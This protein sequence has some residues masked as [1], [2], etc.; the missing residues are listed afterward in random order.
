MRH[1]KQLP[2]TPP[3][4]AHEHAAELTAISTLLD[5][6]PRI[7]AL[8]EQDLLRTCT[9][10]PATGRPGLTGDQV[11][12][13]ALVRQMN[14]WSYDEL[15]FHLADSASYRAFCRVSPLL[16]PPSRAALAANLRRLRPVT[17]EAINALVIT[18][19]AARRIESGQMVRIDAT[20]VVAA[21]H[22]P[23]DASLLWDGIRV[24]LRLL[25]RAEHLAGFTAY[26]THLKRAKRQLLAIQHAAPQATGQRRAAYR[27]LLALARATGDYATCALVHLAASG[28]PRTTATQRLHTQLAHYSGLLE[29]VID[30]TTRRV[31]H[32]ESVPATEKL[33][34]LFETHVDVLVKD[35]RDTYYGHKV[36]LTGGR[37]GLIL[38]CA[39]PKGNPAD[40]TWAVP[41]LQ[42]Q[43]T[44][45]GRPPRQAS[46]DGGFAS[47]DNLT[48]AKALGVRDVCFAKRRGLAV[49]DMVKSS[50]VYRKLKRFRAG[51]E[52]VIS[53]LKRA[54]G[55]DRCTWK[56][57][58]GFVAYVRLGVLT[59][60]LLLLAR[61]QLA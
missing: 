31:F 23:T 48:Q 7:A 25:R 55:L 39:I 49:L 22:A 12:R 10:N 61:H 35:R 56:G 32:G 40:S 59:A 16:A 45:Y 28:R 11:L 5:T 46:L 41:L 57:D 14:E 1:S 52:S 20:V 18:S 21:I 9:K 34:S 38:D 44:L 37:S 13:I 15:A 2:L 4:I 60:N 26:H 50:W 17:L 29:R 33:V 42:R 19:A 6:E 3:W 27:D 43:C 58:T 8:V 47:S 53:L 24:L 54:F 36:F 51:I 30:Q